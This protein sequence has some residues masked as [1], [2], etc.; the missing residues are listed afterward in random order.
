MGGATC[1][2]IKQQAQNVTVQDV[3][4]TVLKNIFLFQGFLNYKNNRRFVAAVTKVGH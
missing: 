3:L 2:F 1:G 4:M